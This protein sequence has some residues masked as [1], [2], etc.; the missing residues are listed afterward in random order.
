[1][2]KKSGLHQKWNSIFPQ[3]IFPQIQEETCAHDT[4]QIQIIGGDADEYQTQIIGGDADENHTQIIGGMQMKT[5]L[6]VLGGDTVKLLGGYILPIPRGFGTPG[7][8][9]PK[10]TLINV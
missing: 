7:S 6:K 10:V 5:T 2:K 1:M 4:Y 8:D 3:I 9:P